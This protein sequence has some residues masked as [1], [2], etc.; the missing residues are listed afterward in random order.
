MSATSGGLKSTSKVTIKGVN[1]IWSGEVP[2]QRWSQFYNK[3]LMKHVMGKK[4]KLKVEVKLED[5]TADDVDE[6][7]IALQELG[8]DD[9]VKT[10]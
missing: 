6:M 7:R 5:V 1:A 4:L 10:V 3:V 8:L 2:H 9:D